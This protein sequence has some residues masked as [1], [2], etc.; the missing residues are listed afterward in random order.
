MFIQAP[1]HLF[2]SSPASQSVLTRRYSVGANSDWKDKLN[3]CLR[4]HEV[5]KRWETKQT[6]TG[7]LGLCAEIYIIYT[8]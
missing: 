1:L 6:Q 8:V 2:L 7:H 3:N 4:G 5:Q